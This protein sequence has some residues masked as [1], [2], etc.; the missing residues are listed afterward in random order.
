MNKNFQMPRVI[1][2]SYSRAIDRL[3]K[4]LQRELAHVASPFFIAD[5]LRRLARSPTFALSCRKIARAMATQL[6]S[7]GHKTWRQAAAAGSKGRLIFES[8]QRE[9][10]SPRVA[11]T[12]DGI[13]SRNAELIKSIPET[14]AGRVSH[15]VAQ[16]YERGLRPEALIKHVLAEYPHMTESHARLIARTETSKASTALTQV[17]ASE[18]G[19]E[20]YV[21]RTSEDARVR[22]AHA[23]MDGVVIPWSEA[24]APEE[25]NGEKSQGNYH[26]G[27]IYNCRCY[28]EP[29]IRFDQV[30]W[31]AKVYLNGK[32]QRM[33]LAKFKKLLPGGEL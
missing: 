5:V 15:M 12:F 23:H 14:L 32:I 16:G 10:A 21:W 28:P 19:L 13:I 17:R 1:E 30:A 8:L 6:F 29:L 3:L 18:A 25:L 22:S 7:D 2:R 31:P 20:W 4:G 24:P 9:L 26:A 27:N 33:S 11:S